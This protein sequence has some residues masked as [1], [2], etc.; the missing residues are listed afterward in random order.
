MKSLILPLVTEII[1]GCA[2]AIS[3]VP[4]AGA[5][6]TFAT[7]GSTTTLAVLVVLGMVVDGDGLTVVD[8]GVGVL[9]ATV[10][11]GTETVVGEAAVVAAAE[12]VA[13][14]VVAAVAELETVT[15]A[16]APPPPEVHAEARTTT[17]MAADT[18]TDRR[19]ARRALIKSASPLRDHPSGPRQPPVPGNDR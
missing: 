19:T 12:V 3:V 11:A 5:A 18:R 17:P 2:G 10:I 8:A 7:G 14:P 4:N 9:L 6:D 16:M 13:A 15:V 1:T